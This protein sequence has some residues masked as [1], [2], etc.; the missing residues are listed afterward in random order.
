MCLELGI[1]SYFSSPHHPQANGQVEAANKILKMNLKRKLDRLKG[2]WVDELPK[3]LWAYRTT[4]RNATGETPFSLSFGAEAVVPVESVVPT[5]RTLH[6]Q[7]EQN[8]SQLRME[9]DLLEERRD[10]ARLRMAAYQQASARFYNSRVKHRSFRPGDLVLRKVMLNTREHGAGALGPTWE[11]P[12][13]VRQV[14]R[15]GTY[16]LTS[17][18]D[19]HLPHP[20]NAEH[21][22]LY[23][24]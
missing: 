4:A 2:A 7:S 22:K 11:G 15:P 24:P 18:T 5:Y 23:Y 8:D 14:I 10:E 21:L 1:K 3:V 16:E 13:K 9:L 6:F 12:Y 19:E 20:W 17:M